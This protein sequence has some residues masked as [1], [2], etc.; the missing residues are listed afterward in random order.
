MPAS[1]RR[2]MVWGE[3]KGRAGTEPLWL[4]GMAPMTG[5][6]SQLKHEAPHCGDEATEPVPLGPGSQAWDLAPQNDGKHCQEQAVGISAPSALPEVSSEI[7][8]SE[9]RHSP[10]ALCMAAALATQVLSPEICSEL[11]TR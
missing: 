2:T 11:R 3:D 8:S 4:T 1:N 5:L 10:S 9:T 7:Q 6:G